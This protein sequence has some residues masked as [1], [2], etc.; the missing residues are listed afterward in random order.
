MGP[1][2]KWILQALNFAMCSADFT[3]ENRSREW[4]DPGSSVMQ[5]TV[6]NKLMIFW[7]KF[8]EEIINFY[9][10]YANCLIYNTNKKHYDETITSKL[11]ECSI[12]LISSAK[13]II[14]IFFYN[15]YFYFWVQFLHFLIQS[16]KWQSVNYNLPSKTTARIDTHGKRYS[17]FWTWNELTQFFT[18]DIN[19]CTVRAG[20]FPFLKIE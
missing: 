9:I 3:W 17:L 5:I 1:Y 10:F 6:K 12:D 16:N 13:I 11:H 8:F 18:R 19:T 15:N 14:I 7:T 2:F 20:F 4:T